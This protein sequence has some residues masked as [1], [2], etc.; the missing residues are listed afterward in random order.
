MFSSAVIISPIYGFRQITTPNALMINTLF[1][2]HVLG[3][4][5]TSLGEINWVAYMYINA[6][7]WLQVKLS[8][9]RV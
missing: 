8:F 6:I 7:R 1:S 3:G 4:V 2:A 5:N 9:Y